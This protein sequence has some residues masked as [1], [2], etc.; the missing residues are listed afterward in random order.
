MLTGQTH[1]LT[2]LHESLQLVAGDLVDAAVGA[3][4]DLASVQVDLCVELNLFH[5]EASAEQGVTDGQSTVVLEQECVV[6]LDV[7][8][9]G[10]GD[11]H[12]GGHTVVTGRN[13]TDGQNGLGEDVL[14]QLNTCNGEGGSH[15]RMRV[16]DGT[17]IGT[18]L[19]H[20]HVHLD[21]G[22][23]VQL[24]V[25]LVAVGIDLD[26][27]VGGHEALGYT[28]GGAVVLVGADLYRDVTVV[29]GNETVIV[30][31]LT[32]V[33]DFFFDFKGRLCHSFYFPFKKIY[34]VYIRLPPVRAG[35]MDL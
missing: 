7:G 32:D 6:L 15:G 1:L 3:C 26:D 27:H 35:G 9:Q 33:N 25:Q 12:G 5:G 21:L 17:C 18:L 8:H 19:I 14:V 31:S 10:L 20:S 2:Q 34:L 24:T 16:N 4:T 11:L 22:G 28:G 29:C 23:G 13:V 30:D